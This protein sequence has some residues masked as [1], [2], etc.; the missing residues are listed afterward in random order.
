MHATFSAVKAS[1]LNNYY[2]VHSAVESRDKEIRKS[3]PQ[4]ALRFILA[5]LLEIVTSLLLET[6]LVQN[7][8]LIALLVGTI[9]KKSKRD[10]VLCQFGARFSSCLV[11]VLFVNQCTNF[12]MIHSADCRLSI[13]F[14]CKF[15]G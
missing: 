11:F 7:Y 2:F 13:Q 4:G 14:V 6:C 10:K 8:S 9:S 15:S 12:T 1:E 3:V 5:L